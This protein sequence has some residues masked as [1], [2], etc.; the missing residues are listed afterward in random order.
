MKQNCSDFHDLV[1]HVATEVIDGL[2]YLHNQRIADRDLKTAKIL[3]SNQHYSAFLLEDEEFGP[4]YQARPIACKLTDFGESHSRFIK[5]Q[6]IIASKTT[7]I[8][9]GTV[10]YMA[11][12]LLVIEKLVPCA[13][14]DDL[15]L[16]DVWALGMIV[17]TMI[18]PSLKCP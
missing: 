15:A 13:S 8:D 4:T 16:S 6:A 7:N 14:I 12:E 10:V 5:T 18:N 9:R 1:C 17:F 3:V 11:P 2:G